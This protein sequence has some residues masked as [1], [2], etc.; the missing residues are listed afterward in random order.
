MAAGER[1]NILVL[2][3]DQ[4]N[5]GFMGCAG[6]SL[7]RTPNLDRLAAGGTR[8]SAAYCASP[9]C[10]PSRMSFMTS[11][12]P[13]RNRVWNNHHVLSSAIPTWAHYLGAAGYETALIGR[14]HFVGADQ[15]H[16]F[17]LRPHGEFSAGH[18]GNTQVGG[19]R[20]R[21]Y[22]GKTTGQ[23][24]AA[25]EVAGTGH[26]TY[27]WFDDRVAGAACDY[28]RERAEDPGSGRPFAAVAGFLLPH[29]TFVSPKELFD[30]YYERVEVPELPERMP[31]AVERYRRFRGLTDP[32]L[33]DE[34]VRIARAAY[35]GMCEFFDRQV[36]RVLDCLDETGLAENTL[37]VYC[38]DHGEQ[39]GEHGCWWKSTYYQG[40]AGVPL[41]ARLPGT[42]AAGAV[43]D[44]VCS[45]MDLGPTFCEAAGAEPMRAADGRSLWGTLRGD[46][47]ADWPDETFSELVDVRT[48]ESDHP[49]L[50][51][52][53]VR[54][55]R[56]KLWTHEDADGLPPVLFDLE[57]DAAEMSDLGSD[58]AH[59]EVRESLLARVRDGWDP[60][61]ARSETL[62]L[63][64]DA[65]A[66]AEWGRAV[67]PE[68]PETLPFPEEDIERDIVLL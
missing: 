18:P 41:V 49:C 52:R 36:G 4:H 42:V 5:V 1:P 15:R 19:E 38:S 37:V 26:S 34:R 25:V 32:E 9:L 20:F 47:A 68:C 48:G 46:H 63:C 27:Q 53:M 10:V 8:F 17:E 51:S 14:M 54:S 57:A 11:R 62:R 28:L 60:E 43:S 21:H 22:P 29:C 67:R 12:T 66:L 33:P 13:S 59:A 6:E 56:W 39:A 24:R 55:G 31:P 23:N 2:M 64:R 58:P 61:L 50:P 30:Y 44:A 40:S 65:A 3:S 35:Y 16:G 7:V 45:L